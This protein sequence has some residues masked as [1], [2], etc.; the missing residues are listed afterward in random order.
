M[1]K[2]LIGILGLV[3]A[4]ALVW[5]AASLEI[6]K[7]PESQTVKA[8]ESVTFSVETDVEL[9][10]SMVWCPAGSFPM[11]SPESELG[12]YSNEKQHKVTISSGFWIGKYEVTQS[13]YEAVMGYNPASSYGV[14]ANYPV[15][16]VSWDNAMD[17]CAKLTAI[18]RSAG[19][20]PEGYEYTLPTEAQWEYACRAGTTTAFNNGT[21]IPKE[22]QTGWEE[23]CPNLDSVAWYWNNAGIYEYT[24]HPVG[25]KKPNAWGIYDMHG[26]VWEWCLDWYGGSYLSSAVTDPKGASTGSNRV[27]RGGSWN[28]YAIYCRS[29]YRNYDYPD[30]DG[31]Y[32]FRV[33]LSRVQ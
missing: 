18:E 15:Y 26:N 32:G 7:Q 16:Y 20:L 13:Q 31:N 27:L 19:R 3:L 4:S 17:F 22:E 5:A 1:K 30:Y 6:I 12:R 9:A 24:S 10:M 33:A 11:G 8:G 21:N 25:Q 29:A 23:P 28:Y 2:I 14:G